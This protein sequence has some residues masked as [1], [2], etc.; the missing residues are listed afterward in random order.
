MRTAEYD[1]KNDYVRSVTS[2]TIQELIDSNM[3][4]VQ[5][6]GDKPDDLCFVIHLVALPPRGF[7]VIREHNGYRVIYHTLPKF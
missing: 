4:L 3:P 5:Q 7:P 6:E 2:G 1:P